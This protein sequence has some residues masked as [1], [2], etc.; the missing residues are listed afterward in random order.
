M[1][2]PVLILGEGVHLTLQEC[3]ELLIILPQSSEDTGVGHCACSGLS[4]NSPL[5]EPHT[6]ELGEGGA[7]PP[8]KSDMTMPT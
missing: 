6:G 7:C 3:L 2:V 5:P 4:L 1:W 8:R